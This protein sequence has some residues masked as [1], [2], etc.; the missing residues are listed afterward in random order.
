MKVNF[1]RKFEVAY[2]LCQFLGISHILVWV[3]QGKK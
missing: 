3:P 2:K 1:P